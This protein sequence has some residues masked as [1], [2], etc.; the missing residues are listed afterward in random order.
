[1]TVNELAKYVVDQINKGNGDK[2]ILIS[3]DDEGNGF[4]G[5]YYAFTDNQDILN[6]YSK[7]GAFH[8]NNDPSSIVILG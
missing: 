7:M 1:M 3:S 4:H 6:E 8:D 2:Q 5:L